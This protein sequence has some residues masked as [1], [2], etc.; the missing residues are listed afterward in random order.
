VLGAVAPANEPSLPPCSAL[1][2]PVAIV[3]RT[4]PE[5]DL[6]HCHWCDT[7][8]RVMLLHAMTQTVDAAQ[9]VDIEAANVLKKIGKAILVFLLVIFLIGLVLGLAIGFFIGKAIGKNSS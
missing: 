1:D 9:V 8:H 3:L 7:M 5:Y 4:A 6:G 2:T